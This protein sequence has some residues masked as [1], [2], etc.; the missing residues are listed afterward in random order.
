MTT[1]EQ[2]FN[3]AELRKPI[4]TKLAKRIYTL[5]GGKEIVFE[6][7]RTQ[8]ELIIDHKFPSQRWIK[9]ES[10]NTDLMKDSE[11]LNK[12]QLLS[13]QTNLLKSKECD[14]CVFEGIRGKFM[15]IKWYYSGD[16]K[17]KGSSMDDEKG[18]VG[19]PWYDT[20]EWKNKLIEQLN[21]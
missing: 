7:Q 16:E 5:L 15:G 1:F 14:R 12:F 13:N 2:E 21:N 8:K 18:C 6:Q 10:D 11:I 19:C 20:Q 17:W 9:A 3:N 4:S